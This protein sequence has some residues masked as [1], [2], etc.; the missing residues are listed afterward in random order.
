MSTK[1]SL[2]KIVNISKEIFKTCSLTD[3]FIEFPDDGVNTFMVHSYWSQLDIDKNERTKFQ[4][5]YLF[6]KEGTQS[7]KYLHCSKPLQ[8]KSEYY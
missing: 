7:A 4:K 2:E 5:T 6:E 8:I 3:A 1:N